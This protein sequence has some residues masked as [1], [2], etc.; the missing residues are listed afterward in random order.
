MCK[1]LASI[2]PEFK[3]L[4]AIKINKWWGESSW[5]NNVFSSH[6]IVFKYVKLVKRLGQKRKQLF[7][8]SYFFG[9]SNSCD[10]KKS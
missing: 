2:I 3:N 8:L 9:T 10:L 6:I 5:V 7:S 4:A 1:I